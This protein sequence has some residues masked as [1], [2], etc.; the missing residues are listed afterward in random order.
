MMSGKS[1][2]MRNM[3]KIFQKKKSELSSQ[4]HSTIDSVQQYLLKRILGGFD[5]L[6]R[7]LKRFS[8]IS[9]STTL[10]EKSSFEI[11]RIEPKDSENSSLKLDLKE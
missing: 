10:L 2:N 5:F 3:G 9:E 7:R 4:V 8:D 1:V 6:T 11:L